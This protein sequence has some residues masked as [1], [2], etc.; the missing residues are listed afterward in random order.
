MYKIYL[1]DNVLIIDNDAAKYND[2]EIMSDENFTADQ[3]G[4]TKLLQKLQNTKRTVLICN[5]I[6][7]KKNEILFLFRIIPAAG[8]V[9]FNDRNDILMI[10]RLDKWDLPKGKTEEDEDC[11]TCAVREVEE[12]CGIN[13]VERKKFLTETCHLYEPRGEWIAKP[14]K[15]Y[16]M[17]YHGSEK[18]VPQTEENISEARWVTEN[19]IHE[20]MKDTYPTIIDVLQ[21]AGIK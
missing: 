10:R 11:K 4:R 15:W 2:G 12:E 21:S 6:I 19:E 5:D 17:E 7:E 9:V 14:T 1:N 13:G 3:V 16:L 18:P 20:Y 8:G